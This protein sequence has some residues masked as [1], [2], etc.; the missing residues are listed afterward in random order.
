MAD[1]L[2]IECSCC[3]APFPTNKKG[4]YEVGT[5]CP[6]GCPVWVDVDDSGFEDEAEAYLVEGEPED[7]FDEGTCK[8]CAKATDVEKEDHDG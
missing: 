2:T 4:L 6:N 3:G 8:S 7:W 5:K 1:G